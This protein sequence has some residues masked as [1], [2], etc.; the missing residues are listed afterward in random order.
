DF[1]GVGA[2]RLRLD[3]FGEAVQVG[4]EIH[5]FAAR[6]IDLRL[7]PDPLLDRAK[8]V[9]EVKIARGL[10]AGNDAHVFSL[11][12]GQAARRRTSAFK[13]P[14]RT[15]PVPKQASAYTKHPAPTSTSIALVRI[16]QSPAM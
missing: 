14:I 4:D 12:K 2:Q 9:A 11:V 7:H 16:V 1:E 10:D 5:A 15:A 3:P 6:R 8:I 13:S